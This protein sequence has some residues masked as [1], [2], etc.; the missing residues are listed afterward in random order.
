[1]ARVHHD[2]HPISVSRFCTPARCRSTIAPGIHGESA[3]S[4]S[5][6]AKCRSHVIGR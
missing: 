1:M 4:S 2:G 3:K 5:I 6:L